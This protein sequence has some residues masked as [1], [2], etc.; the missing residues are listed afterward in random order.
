MLAKF[1][2]KLGVSIRELHSVLSKA[3]HSLERTSSIDLSSSDTN[4]A[5]SFII[6]VQELKRKMLKWS[7]DVDLYKASQKSLEKNRFRF[8]DDWLYT[9]HLEGEWSAFNSILK[10]KKQILMDET[11]MGHY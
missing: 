6:M 4:E 8:P 3:R 10:K 5:V 9:D 11:G 2:S 7:E 1:G